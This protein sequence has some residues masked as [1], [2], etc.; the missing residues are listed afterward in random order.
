MKPL[1]L[2][3][4]GANHLAASSLITQIQAACVRKKVCLFSHKD[5][6][7]N[8]NV[9]FIEKYA[10]SRL[11]K[12][13]KVYEESQI[14]KISINKN[15]TQAILSTSDFRFNLILISRQHYKFCFYKSTDFFLKSEMTFKSCKKEENTTSYFYPVNSLSKNIICPAF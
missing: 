14:I 8:I 10:D 13:M 3:A 2:K 5:Q 7:Y 12:L 15:G 11:F 9:E 1:R 6:L 4:V